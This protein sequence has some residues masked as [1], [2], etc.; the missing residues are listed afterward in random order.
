ML[1]FIITGIATGAIYGLAATGLVLTYRTAGVFNFAYGAV[2]AAA[3]YSFY[4]LHDVVNMPWVPAALIALV[5]FGPVAG[6]VFEVIGRGLS[7]QSTAMKVAG[8]IGIIL[9][10]EALAT[11]KFGPSQLTV[12]QFLPHGSDTFRLFGANVTYAELIILIVAVIGVALLYWLLRST[13]L[14]VGMRAVVDD[15]GLVSLH[16]NSPVRIRRYA[17]IAG[18]TFAALSGILIAP[19]VGLQSINLTYLVV[20]AF[21]A[22]AI[23]MFANIPLTFVG[24]LALGIA[25]SLSTKWVVQYTW[26]QGLPESLP[27]IA[28]VVVMLVTPRRRLAPPTAEVR[29]SKL[30][31]RAPAA[32]RLLMGV[33][34]L[35]LFLC[36]PL[37]AGGHI[38]YYV[39]G[40]SEALLL[41]S[42]GLLV[43][44][45]GVVSLCQV[46]FAAIGAVAFAQFMANFHMPW[47][48]AVLL[49]G[50]VTVPVAAA[51]SLPAIR[52][53]G[54]F[55]ALATLGFAIMME[56]I[57]YPMNFMFT[58]VGG[59]RKMPRPSYASTD[60]GYYFVVLAIVAVFAVLIYLIHRARLGRLLSG[61][62][63]SPVSVRSMG[64]N[65]NVTRVIVFCIAG[66]MAGIAGILYGGALHV[67]S[68]T[69]PNY[70]SFYSLVLLALLVI[71]PMR[72]PWYALFAVVAAVI[73]G[74]L[75]SQ[76]TEYWLNG[77]F[78][79]FAVITALSGGTQ[80]MPVRLQ[81]VFDRVLTPPS[82]W[83]VR[84]RPKV[85]EPA[86]REPSVVPAAAGSR[87]GLAVQGVT[88]RFGGLT[89]LRDVSLEAPL[90]RI[91]G[92]IGPNGAGKTTLFNACSG[93]VRPA[94]GRIELHGHDITHAGPA[95][96]AARGLGRTFQIMQLCDTLTVADN[97]ALGCEAGQAGSRPWEQVIAPPSQS[98]AARLAVERAMELC[99]ITNLAD[100]QAGALATGQRRLV[101]LARCLA[102][103]FD[104]L[105]LDEPSSGLTPSE[106]DQFA[107]TLRYVVRQSGKGILLVE[108]D[109]GLVMDICSYVYVLDFGSVLFEGEPDAV[110]NSPLVQSAYLGQDLPQSALES[111]AS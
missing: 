2:A 16:G 54:I 12:P 52:L 11:L 92:L 13:R 32:G 58:V 91:T 8:T 101:E 36:V 28:L 62:S 78:G 26:L 30:E 90:G 71:S 79:V 6:L 43:R 102:G 100:R 22:A 34:L 44:T 70:A 51:V 106:T 14:G 99:R 67:A 72:T 110:T 83:L 37:F 46:S 87:P 1:P 84:Q 80:Q 59:G 38:T 85:A 40:L 48:L 4:W 53:S 17:W 45:A 41:L 3:A 95:G 55:L 68:D 82:R 89:A 63:E 74:Y 65:I 33:C 105:L 97:V 23:G 39:I 42:L 60:T 18:T 104:V 31:W 49:G 9:V 93:L 77:I 73:P 66:F 29:R 109:M 86:P 57:F 107:E 35:A 56:Q 75:T 24:G 76:N 94:G 15:P 81:A 96:R 61:L 50:L 27:F 108:H 20:E 69:D 98:K 25:S 21:G 103:D 7:R 47:L 111:S 19:I 5:V 10:V 64:L 88:V